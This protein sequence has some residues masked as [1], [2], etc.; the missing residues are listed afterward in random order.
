MKKGESVKN[1]FKGTL[2]F[3]TIL[4]ILIS[5]MAIV[6][7]SDTMELADDSLNQIPASDTVMTETYGDEI[8]DGENE[9]DNYLLLRSDFD[10]LI[11]KTIEIFKTKPNILKKYKNQF[12]HIILSKIPNKY[13]I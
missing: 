7:A 1:N 8:L 11:N 4:I 5:C 12:K 10:D 2:I 9:S 13:F 6:S 3:L